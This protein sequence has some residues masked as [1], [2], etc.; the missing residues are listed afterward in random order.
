[1]K[2]DCGICLDI[3][4]AERPGHDVKWPQLIA[5]I[6]VD[7]TGLKAAEWNYL[8]SSRLVFS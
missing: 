8:V 6:N 1:M 4:L 7:L 2:G 3:S 5:V